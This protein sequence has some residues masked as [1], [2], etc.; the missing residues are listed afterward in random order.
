MKSKLLMYALCSAVALSACG[1]GGDD[2]TSAIA[3]T[4]AA[5][6]AAAS[7]AAID[8]YVGTW[9]G[10]FVDRPTDSFRETFT[11][12]KQGNTSLL[13]GYNSTR[14]NNG[15]C[16]EAGVA[17]QQESATLDFSNGG[18]KLIGSR[19]VEKFSYQV[20]SPE[21]ASGKSVISLQG[22]ALQ[23]GTQGQL[24][25]AEGYPSALSPTQFLKQ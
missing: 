15:T 21:A 4:P 1:G 5:S 25:D 24:L 16:A 7:G 11:F 14:H 23:L 9:I 19:T 17:H 2:E 18:T 13:S 22:T 12:T 10:C 3:A 6:D 20:T 8:K